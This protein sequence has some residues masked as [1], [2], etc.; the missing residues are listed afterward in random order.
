M[1][2]T[3]QKLLCLTALCFSVAL[4]SSQPAKAADFIDTSGDVLQIAI[5]A[6]AYAT[7]FYLDDSEGRREFYKS[8]FTSLG[9]TYGLKYSIDKKRPNGKEHSFPSGHTSAAFQGATFIHK[10]YGLEY[11][12]PAYIG[13]SFVGY[14]RIETRNHDIVDVLAGAAIGAGSSFFFTDRYNGLSVT[15]VACDGYVGITIGKAW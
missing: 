13:A 1:L 2:S 3:S 7:T 12:I 9:V 8:F 10:R 6:A 5:P 11:G 15:P 14:S 4:F